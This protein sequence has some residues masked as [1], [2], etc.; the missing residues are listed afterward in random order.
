MK[1]SISR[2]CLL[3]ACLSIPIATRLP[4]APSTELPA[5]FYAPLE[6]TAGAFALVDKDTGQLRIGSVTAANTASFTGPFRTH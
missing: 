1:S 6:H 3:L 5:E 2:C 4:A